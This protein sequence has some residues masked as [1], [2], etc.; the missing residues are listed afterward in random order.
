MS[1]MSEAEAKAI[2]ENVRR[3]VQPAFDQVAGRLAALEAAQAKS[4]ADA[5]QGTYLTAKRY[6]RG[7][8]CTHAGSLWLCLAETTQRPG[9]DGSWRLIVKAGRDAA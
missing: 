5:Y 3:F 8:L 4:L 7:Q 9:D 6:E 1:G 2:L